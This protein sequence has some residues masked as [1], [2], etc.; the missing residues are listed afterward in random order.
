MN[1]VAELSS[2]RDI[3]GLK[4]RILKYLYDWG[5]SDFTYLSL[6][7][8]EEIDGPLLTIS[9]EQLY[10]YKAEAFFDHDMI[11]QYIHSNTNPIFQSTID[12]F[13][14][15]TPF[16]T[17]LISRNRELLRMIKS[18]GYKEW[19]MMPIK[20]HESGAPALFSVSAKMRAALTSF[21]R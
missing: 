2:S 1:F 6:N 9:K 20:V 18:F 8:I 5:F 17:E 4:K 15:S 13:L 7:T 11:A 19:Y 10:L 12:D 16:V 3:A 14:N 21:I